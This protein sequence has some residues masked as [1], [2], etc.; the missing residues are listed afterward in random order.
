MLLAIALIVA[1][2]AVLSHTA[3][4]PFVFE[5]FRPA[6]S[7][8]RGP[9]ASGGPPTIYLSFDDGPN[10]EWTPPLL[11]ALRDTEIRATFFL[12]DDHITDESA[13]IVRRIADEGH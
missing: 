10:P 1:G 6:R 5:A 3:P 8:W 9:P 7:L 12:I 11:D 4:F 13:P 2:A